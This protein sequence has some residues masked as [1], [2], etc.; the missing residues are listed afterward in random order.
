MIKKR[1]AGERGMTRTDWLTSHHT[2]SFNRYYDPRYTG[3]RQLLV[4]N[5]DFVAPTQGFGAHS[6]RDM[7]IITYV[8]AGALEHKDSMG[9]SSVIRPGEVQ[10]MSAGTGVTHSE[11]NPSPDEPVHFLQIWIEPE[12]TGLQP[13]YEQKEIPAA[14]RRGKFRLIAS[15]A[16]RDGSITI[17]QDAEMYVATLSAGEEISYGL[18]TGRHAW[19]QV[20]QGA[21]VVNETALEAGDGAAI[22]GEER[23]VIRADRPSEVM[24]FD[25]A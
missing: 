25:L 12:R 4:I 23:I 18:K 24:L 13:S 1:P 2:F 16:G 21:G 11:Y 15:R 6:H 3:F 20:L 7:E 17:Q 9:T 19:L 14:E 22:S 8:L 5:E 10:R